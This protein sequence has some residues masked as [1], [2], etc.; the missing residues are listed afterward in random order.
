M[1]K[2][3]QQA[4][5]DYLEFG[6]LSLTQNLEAVVSPEAMPLL[7]SELCALLQ[8]MNSTLE[9]NNLTTPVKPKKQI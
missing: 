8:D 4:I 1:N 5:I 2:N 3:E 6:F 9:C 7:R